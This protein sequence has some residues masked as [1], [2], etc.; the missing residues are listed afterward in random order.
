[1]LVLL[2]AELRFLAN[3][4]GIMFPDFL[5]LILCREFGL[6]HNGTVRVEK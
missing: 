1:M 4:V 5:C 6:I 2:M 3:R